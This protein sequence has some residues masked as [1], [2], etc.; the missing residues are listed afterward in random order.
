[1]IFVEPVTG[2]SEL[3]EVGYNSIFSRIIGGIWLISIF[4]P[5]YL[6]GNFKL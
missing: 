1:M 2:T 5:D 4:A 3:V 6:K